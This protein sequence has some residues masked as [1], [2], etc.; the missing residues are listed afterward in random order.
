MLTDFIY[1]KYGFIFLCLICNVAV[2]QKYNNY[3]EVDYE[4]EARLIPDSHYVHAHWEMSYI[5]LST[6]T[7]DALY[8]EVWP[9]AFLTK[10]TVFAQ[11]ELRLN[12]I[13]FQMAGKDKIGGIKSLQFN[14]GNED[15]EW[16]YVSS[17]QLDII[18][19]TLKNSLL[20]NEQITV[21]SPFTLKVPGEGN[22]LGRAD[23]NFR[24]Q[25][26]YP[27]IAHKENSGWDYK[28][29]N[30][31]NRPVF[32]Q[33]STN[34]SFTIPENY[35][36]VPNVGELTKDQAGS[37]DEMG[38]HET[39]RITSSSN[40]DM[41][42]VNLWV[43]HDYECTDTLIHET[44]F[45]ICADSSADLSHILSICDEVWSYIGGNYGFVPPRALSIISQGIKDRH[46]E[47]DGRIIFIDNKLPKEDQVI[48][49][50]YKLV[51]AYLYPY[52]KSKP[53]ADQ[54][55]QQ[56]IPALI[57]ESILKNNNLVEQVNTLTA[58]FT[59]DTIERD[60]FSFVLRDAQHSLPKRGQDVKILSVDDYMFYKHRLPARHMSYLIDYLSWDKWYQA[61]RLCISEQDVDRDLARC[62][63]RALDFD[64]QGTYHSMWA[65]LDRLDI[66]LSKSK[67]TDSII[68]QT[69]VSN[70][71]VDV[72]LIY[73][74]QYEDI[75][76]H[77]TDDVGQ[78]KIPLEK[79]VIYYEAN[80]S[81]IVLEKT[82]TNNHYVIE[83]GSLSKRNTHNIGWITGFQN[84]TQNT[85][86][87]MPFIGY[88]QRDGVMP[89]LVIHNL[90]FPPQKL[91][92]YVSPFLGLNSG[93]VVG[94]GDIGYNLKVKHKAINNIRLGLHAKS[95]QYFYSGVREQELRFIKLTPNIEVDIKTKN[96]RFSRQIMALR[97]ISL[98]E[99]NRFEEGYNHTFIH[100]MSYTYV[101]NRAY[102]P[103][104]FIVALE[105]QSYE[106]SQGNENYLKIWA[107]WKGQLNINKTDRFRM[108]VFAGTFLINTHQK[109]GFI[110]PGDGRGNFSLFGNS[111][112]DYRYDQNFI[113]RNMTTG[114]GANQV[115][116]TDGGFKNA[117]TRQF[118]DGITNRYIMA[119]N[120][121]SDLPQLPKWLPLRPYVDGGYTAGLEPRQPNAPFDQ[122]IFY[123][124]G[125]GIHF[126]NDVF[127]I[128]I[129]IVNSENIERF[130][131]ERGGFLSRISFSWQV[132]LARP[133]DI[134]R[135]PHDYLNFN[136]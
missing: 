40:W 49:L 131:N 61:C 130:Y 120:L 57:A 6:D 7:I 71:P 16:S 66:A 78:I 92:Y 46:F 31:W 60:L 2:S 108:R 28:S 12:N 32:Q 122:N 43:S 44:D 19:V 79:G 80:P 54:F 25:Y 128:Y 111:A 85:Q 112:L 125:I 93:R 99:Q 58:L 77:K 47:S 8:I 33:G 4:I 50:T 22:G 62:L 106:S 132:G 15:L 51:D 126:L 69:S 86:F 63:N 94:F 89:G 52:F 100:E 5:N 10:Q 84:R 119:V 14:D 9:N 81:R 135:R 38:K 88:N 56:S 48:R 98:W 101:N 11:E 37:S 107:E 72:K 17:S 82:Y 91:E 42:E 55:Y 65:D 117:I 27:R 102:N 124:G 129:P 121:S 118:I 24:L 21:S 41:P 68:I 64:L 75:V 18:K 114:V 45:N 13:D 136:Y 73:D 34:V 20:P 26:W 113:G 103:Y 127:N 59:N 97:S 87:V 36:I 29:F 134:L 105:Q 83:S 39:Y 104:R 76:W 35:R 74:D 110:T 23:D 123:S 30:G 116:I 67:H 1:K 53:T 70:F 109:H 115:S 95:F 3:Y 90:S 133:G 96:P